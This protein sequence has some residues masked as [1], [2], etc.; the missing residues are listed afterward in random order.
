MGVS[1]YKM[2]KWQDDKGNPVSCTE[3]IKVM[4]Q[5][6]DELQQ[7]AQDTFEDAILMGCSEKQVRAFLTEL[8]QTLENPYQK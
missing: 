4:Q 5:N 6:L 3:K 1:N 2:P 7:M 8:M